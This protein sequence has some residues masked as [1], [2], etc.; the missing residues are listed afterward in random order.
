M[1]HFIEGLGQINIDSV[2]LKVT[3]HSWRHKVREFDQICGRRSAV[4]KTVLQWYYI[5]CNLWLDH[6]RYNTFKQFREFKHYGK[7]AI[8]SPI[9]F[10]SRFINRNNQDNFPCVWLPG[11]LSDQIKDGT[12]G[13]SQAT[14]IINHKVVRYPYHKHNWLF[15]AH[16]V[17]E[18]VTRNTPYGYDN[19]LAVT[20]L[21][22]VF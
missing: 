21:H 12:Q 7:G 11:W 18:K 17:S 20:T 14:N 15:A 22:C 16:S 13:S 1:V 19:S 6:Y 4:S 5:I 9:S 2:N 10:L 8:T 3:V